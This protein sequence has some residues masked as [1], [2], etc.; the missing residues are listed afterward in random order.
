M[1]TRREN[2][3]YI[4]TMISNP[5]VVGCVGKQECSSFDLPEIPPTNV[6]LVVES[7]YKILVLWPKFKISLFMFR[8]LT[9]STFVVP[10][11]PI[12]TVKNWCPRLKIIQIDKSWFPWKLV[13]LSLQSNWNPFTE[14][15]KFYKY[16]LMSSS[17]GLPSSVQARVTYCLQYQSTSVK[18]VYTWV[19][20]DWFF[21]YLVH[22]Q[23]R[24]ER[25][26]FHQSLYA[27]CLSDILLAFLGTTGL[28]NFL[29]EEVVQRSYKT[30]T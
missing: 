14:V 5:T 18:W 10:F 25:I 17:F 1:V 28:V 27:A 20:W 24:L 22:L 3:P 15:W 9:I 30:V 26:S 11:R 21:V 16:H 29:G 23:F 13:L 19:C 4:G 12:Q 2:T 8:T 6:L 7:S